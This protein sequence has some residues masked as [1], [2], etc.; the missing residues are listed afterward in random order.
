MTPEERNARAIRVRALMDDA[1]IKAAFD[2]IEADL[3]AEWKSAREQHER[4]NCW[5][6]LRVMERLQVWLQSAATSDLTALR[7]S[8]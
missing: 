4:E 2:S 7:R 3:I 5:H 1:D 6:A 8:R